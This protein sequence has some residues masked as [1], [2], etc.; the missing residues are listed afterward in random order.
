MLPSEAPALTPPVVCT[1]LDQMGGASPAATSQALSPS[2]VAE[3]FEALNHLDGAMGDFQPPSSPTLRSQGNDAEGQYGS[4][5]EKLPIKISFVGNCREE[6]HSPMWLALAPPT[7]RAHG[8]W[9]MI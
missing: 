7:C 8:G 9:G 1:A 4:S 2:P 6:L 5:P 3:D